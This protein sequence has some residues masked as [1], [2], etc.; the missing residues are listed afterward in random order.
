MLQIDGFYENFGPAGRVD[1]IL[2][3]PPLVESYTQQDEDWC[4]AKNN[5]QAGALSP[6]DT[7]QLE[8]LEPE[9]TTLL[10]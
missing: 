9:S 8:P 3:V 2:N 4:Q 5:R 6:D 10:D 7:S 1:T